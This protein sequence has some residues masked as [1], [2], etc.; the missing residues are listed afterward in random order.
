MKIRTQLIVAFLVLA[1]LPMAVIVLFNY[2][3]SQRAVRQAVEAAV[4]DAGVEWSGQVLSVVGHPAVIE[5][6]EDVE[7]EA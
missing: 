3:S 2:L 7:P 6:A 5:A 1:V 4:R